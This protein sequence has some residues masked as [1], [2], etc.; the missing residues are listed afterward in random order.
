MV[1]TMCLEGTTPKDRLLKHF[2]RRT[3]FQAELSRLLSPRTS[4]PVTVASLRTAFQADNTIVII[5]LIQ[6]TGNG[7]L[8]RLLVYS[9]TRLLVYSF[10]RLLVYSFTNALI[11]SS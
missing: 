2:H 10:T 8:S 11:I 3:A 7:N 4:S 6:S 9:F 1:G 5:C